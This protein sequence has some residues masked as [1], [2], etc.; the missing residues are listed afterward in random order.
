[1]ASR[2]TAAFLLVAVALLAE[3][4]LPAADSPPGSPATQAQGP[5]FGQPWEIDVLSG[6][7]PAG[8]NEDVTMT[9]GWHGP[10]ANGA[11]DIRGREGTK[12]YRT[13]QTGSAQHQ[14]QRVR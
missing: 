12:V 7:R 2:F 14:Y 10:P 5:P 9:S 8:T 3:H 6:I 13:L 1:M 4:A 11:L